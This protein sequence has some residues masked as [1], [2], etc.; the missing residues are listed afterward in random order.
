[1]GQGPFLF[2]HEMVKT[3]LEDLRTI[4]KA[5]GNRVEFGER[6]SRHS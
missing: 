5:R 2:T 3:K 1:M 4:L 6:F